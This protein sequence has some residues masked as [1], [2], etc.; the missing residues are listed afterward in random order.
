MSAVQDK[1]QQQQQQR[2]ELSSPSIGEP[3]NFIS[4][5]QHPNSSSI[6]HH[7]HHHHLLH[8]DEPQHP[9]QMKLRLQQSHQQSE[10]QPVHT[11]QCTHHHHN[12]VPTPQQPQLLHYR[13][14]G[15]GSNCPSLATPVGTGFVTHHNNYNS[16]GSPSSLLHDQCNES[17][18]SV[19]T[20]SVETHVL[21]AHP[22]GLSSLENNSSYALGSSGTGS[23]SAMSGTIASVIA[24]RP[25]SRTSLLHCECGANEQSGR[26]SRIVSTDDNNPSGSEDS[27]RKC[28]NRINR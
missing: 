1:Q 20:A 4:C 3:N 11:C 13:R 22:V 23:A 14:H 28:S 17:L 5:N 19:T 24:H 15:G 21:T 7:H 9:H 16:N 26:S 6:A 2:S 25:P 18:Q 27:G 10:P 12:I 8:H